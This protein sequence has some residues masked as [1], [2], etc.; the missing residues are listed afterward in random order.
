MS[1]LEKVTSYYEKEHPF[2]EGITILRKLAKETDLKE[3][4]K[5]QFPTYTLHGKNVFSIC[6]FK[7]HFGVWFFKGVLLNDRDNV[8]VNAQKGKTKEMRHWKFKSN[9]E[10][11]TA[12]VREY[13]M[14]AILNQQQGKTTVAKIPEAI[15]VPQLLAAA[16]RQDPSLQKAF[17]QL[18]TSK[19][20]AYALYI[21]D[22]KRENTKLNR[23]QKIIPMIKKGLGLSDKYR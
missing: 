19:Q 14:E 5:W 11:N 16:L 6:R 7:K 9:Q 12:L 22:A 15:V 10:I 17:Y 1:T 20:R 23:L 2:K 13:F 18:T 21:H 4:Y 8:L 3:D